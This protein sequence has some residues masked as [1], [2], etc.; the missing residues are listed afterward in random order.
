MEL[1]KG[2]YKKPKEHTVKIDTSTHTELRTLAY[3]KCISR[4]E[5]VRRAIN[6]YRKSIMF[7]NLGSD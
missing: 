2:E 5:I 6:L 1:K 4:K 3:K 7:E